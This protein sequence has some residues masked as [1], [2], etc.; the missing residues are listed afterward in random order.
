MAEQQPGQRSAE[1]DVAL[2]E[3]IAESLDRRL[4]SHSPVSS[5]ISGDGLVV[6]HQVEF[7]TVDGTRESH[8]IYI[9]TSPRAEDR[10]GVLTM[11]DEESGDQVSVW[12]YPRDPALPALQ[13]AASPDGAEVIL[14]RLGVD[15]G[16]GIALT[17]AAYRPG[18]RAVIRVDTD[19]STLFL[20]IVAPGIAETFA[21][22]HNAWLE[23]GLPVPRVLGWSVEGL[24]AL[25]ALGGTPAIDAIAHLDAHQFSQE[26][27][28]LQQL[29][30]AVPSTTSARASLSSRLSW[31]ERRLAQSSPTQ[32]TRVHEIA[33]RI[34]TA[35][36]GAAVPPQVTVHGD[37]HIGQLFL[38]ET[39]DAVSGLLD[40][41]T[42]GLGDPADDAA[43]LYAHLIVT[44]AINADHHAV[45][46]G[47]KRIATQWRESW[48]EDPAFARRASAIAATHLIA[49]AL[50]QALDTDAL[51]ERAAELLTNG[52]DDKH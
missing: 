24:L 52:A 19:R 1:P 8:L 41:D 43:A 45:T 40:I 48:S 50:N 12:V 34:E 4:I 42:A 49:H 44:A 9:E 25:S 2:L 28:H 7:D 33:R 27:S 26:I 11:R 31:Y 18:K 10:D 35:L 16:T 15:T 13:A 5:E 17:L 3:A 51:L 6:A 32:A 30:A 20:K 21:Q 22:R 14:Q 36:S 38:S 29:M 37:L 47:C 39:T 23:A 46:T